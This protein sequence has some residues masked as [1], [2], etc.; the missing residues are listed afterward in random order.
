MGCS[1]KRKYKEGVIVKKLKLKNKL[2]DILKWVS[3]LFLPALAT[4][5][6]LVSKTWDL[7]YGEQI[8][9]TINGLGVFIGALIGI[10]TANYNKG[11]DE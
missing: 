11:K 10:S 9:I 1:S 3:I 8:V 7:P 4:F 6:G 5:Y 2:Y